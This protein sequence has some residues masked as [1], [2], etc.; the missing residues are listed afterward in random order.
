MPPCSTNWRKR[1]QPVLARGTIRTGVSPSARHVQAPRGQKHSPLK[2]H[3]SHSKFPPAPQTQVFDSQLHFIGFSEGGAERLSPA[4][5]LSEAKSQS[6]HR[7]GIPGAVS[8]G[9]GGPGPAEAPGSSRRSR[10]PGCVPHGTCTAASRLFR[11]CC[12]TPVPFLTLSG[13]R[14]L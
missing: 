7:A 2:N 10:A 8:A 3:P 5:P 13:G 1:T 14:W 4:A 6:R 11:S 12:Q 9:P